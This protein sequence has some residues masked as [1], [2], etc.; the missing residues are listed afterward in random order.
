MFGRIFY[1]HLDQKR[2]D[3]RIPYFFMYLHIPLKAARI[4]QQQDVQII[5]TMRRFRR[6]RHLLTCIAENIGQII[7][8]DLTHAARTVI[9]PEVDHTVDKIQTIQIKMRPD[10]Q[11]QKIH[12]YLLL[13]QFPLIKRN[14]QPA[15]LM[16]HVLE[17]VIDPLQFQQA[18]LRQ[19]QRILPAVILLQLPGKPLRRLQNIS[20]QINEDH[21]TG[22]DQ[23]RRQHGQHHHTAHHHLPDPLPG[24]LHPNGKRRLRQL[25]LD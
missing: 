19:M 24:D 1:K 14:L 25:L 13:L 8:R 22:S 17:L 10:L 12:L 2:K 16:D 21:S 11:F 3:L 20:F 15:D 9:L 5:L 23:H 4:T 7:R 6:H 18:L